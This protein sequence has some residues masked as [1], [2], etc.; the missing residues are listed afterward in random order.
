MQ[1]ALEVLLLEQLVGDGQVAGGQHERVLEP[2]PQRGQELGSVRPV[3]DAVVPYERE[4]HQGAFPQLALPHDGLGPD[5]PHGQNRGLGRVQDR[6]EGADAVH[7]QVGHRERPPG[8][9]RRGDLAGADALRERGRRKIASIGVHARDW[10][11]WHGFA[12]NV[13]T[14]LS[15]FG[16]IVPCGIQGVDMT[17]VS[18]ELGAPVE[19]ARVEDAVARAFG[20][21][22]DLEPAPLP[23][24]GLSTLVVAR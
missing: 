22:F 11:T 21:V 16:L 10:V 14:D 2:G 17:S 23:D 19:M 9:L 7:P 4:R 24:G 3:E 8:E 13:A 1:G 6:D 20:R 18:R 5:R 12:L 15:Y